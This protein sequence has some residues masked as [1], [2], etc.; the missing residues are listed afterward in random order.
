MKIKNRP[1]FIF[2]SL[3]KLISLEV[4]HGDVTCVRIVTLLCHIISM[5]L[6]VMYEGAYHA[7]AH[8]APTTS[9]LVELDDAEQSRRRLGD[10][11][12]GKM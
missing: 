12:H 8:A 2:S 10:G 7:R 6:Y 9:S 3:D 1:L 11:W 5:N 4:R